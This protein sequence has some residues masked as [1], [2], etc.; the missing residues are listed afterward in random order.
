MRALLSLRDPSASIPLAR[1]LLVSGWEVV[2]T[3]ETRSVLAMRGICTI[4]ISEFIG[5]RD[6]HSFPPTLHPRIE[7]ALTTDSGQKI[8]LLWVQPY[9]FEAGLDIGGHTLIALA[10]K[11]NRWV[12]VD[13][14]DAEKFSALLMEKARPDPLRCELR[15]K[16]IRKLVEFYSK[17]DRKESPTFQLQHGENPYEVPAYLRITDEGDPLGFGG[18]SLLSSVPP[19]FTNVADLDSIVQIMMMLAKILATNFSKTPKIAIAAKHGNPCGVGADWQSSQIA[20]D[21]A[22]WG[23]ARGIWGGELICNFEIDRDCVDSLLRSPEREKRCGSAEWMLDVVVAPCFEA[24]ALDLLL[25]RRQRHIFQNPNLCS[26]EMAPFVPLSRPIRGAVMYQPGHSFVL[27][28]P[29]SVM[30]D[31]DLAMDLAIAWAVVSGSFHGGNEVALVKQARL[32]AA[33]GGPST[34]DAAKTAV[35]RAKGL[36]HELS[37]SVFAADA[38]FPYIDAPSLLCDSGCYYGVVPGG[39]RRFSEI[40]DVFRTKGVGCLFL[41]ESVR[42]FCRH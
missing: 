4:P 15:K 5:Y 39:G 16:A 3:E 12:L 11:G 30:E 34:L 37:K 17:I 35:E 1:Q 27:K 9:L 29:D 33:G 6:K 13:S 42:G 25:T 28:L 26:A 10:I 24:S 32:L 41:E 22:L 36:G 38:F 31:P 40:Q 21:R 8:D 14:R 19:C 7:D 2:S 18:F 23:N 20:L